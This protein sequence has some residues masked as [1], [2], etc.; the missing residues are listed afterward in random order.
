MGRPVSRGAMAREAHVRFFD[1]RRAR[2][3][4]TPIHERVQVDGKP[5]QLAGLVRQDT[6]TDLSES[7]DKLDRYATAGAR[8]LRC[9]AKLRGPVGILVTGPFQFFRH[10]ILKWNFL[11]CLPGLARSVMQAMSPMVKH[12]KAHERERDG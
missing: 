3:T 7:L 1:R 8:K 6:C 11:N 12:L 9:R 5:G 4:D 10:R 2:L